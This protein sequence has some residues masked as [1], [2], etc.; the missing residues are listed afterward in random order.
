[1][2]EDDQYSV[3]VN[4]PTVSGT[5]D[6]KRHVYIRKL[7]NPPKDIPEIK[8]L[9]TKDLVKRL[10]GCI[11]GNFS[12]EGIQCWRNY[13]VPPEYERTTIYF[14]IYGTVIILIRIIPNSS[15]I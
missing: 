9:F 6:E 1:M 11:G 14:Q 13:H 15:F 5:K 8:K 3:Q 10:E 12:V 4:K 7:R 2:I